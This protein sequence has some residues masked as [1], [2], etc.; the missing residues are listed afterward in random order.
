MSFQPSLRADVTRRQLL[1]AAGG[2]TVAALIRTSPARADH[3]AAGAAEAARLATLAALLAAVATGPAGGMDD[4]IAAAYVTGYRAYRA[5]ADPLF[6]AYADATLDEI[7][8]TGIGALEPQAAYAELVAWSV[9]GRRAALA[10]AAVDLTQ[11][12]FGEDEARQ[13]GYSL[14]RS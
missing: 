13:A 10:A 3:D 9:D 11:L 8:A 5:D 14:S 7:G 2:L 1:V 4:A 12:A 6:L